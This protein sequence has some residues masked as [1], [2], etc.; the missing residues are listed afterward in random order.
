LPHPDSNDLDTTI[1]IEN[2]QKEGEQ[3]IDGQWIPLIPMIHTKHQEQPLGGDNQ[4]K[5]E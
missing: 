4:Q 1:S 3:Q 5:L 2:N